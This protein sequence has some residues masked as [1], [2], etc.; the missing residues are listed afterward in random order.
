MR[1]I[2]HRLT[3]DTDW[4]IQARSRAALRPKKPSVRKLIR[5]MMGGDQAA[6]VIVGHFNRAQGWGRE[7]QA[8]RSRYA[9]ACLSPRGS[10]RLCRYSETPQVPRRPPSRAD[11][12]AA[13]KRACN[14]CRYL[15]PWRAAIGALAIGALAIGRLEIRKAR[16]REVKIDSL[17][18][19]RF[20][21]ADGADESENSAEP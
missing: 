11:A 15:R 21:V 5:Y 4:W 2:V 9:P 18:V 12:I 1:K 13:G 17:I 19:R 8:K 3:C 10:C 14:G 7:S 6:V 16:L 20:N